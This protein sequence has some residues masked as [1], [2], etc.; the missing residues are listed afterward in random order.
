MNAKQ[1]MLRDITPGQVKMIHA[2]AGALGF[3]EDLYREI[4]R[5]RFKVRSS[6][7]L[8][9]FQAGRLIEELEEK[10]IQA[11]VW[12]KSAFKQRYEAL[13]GRPGFASVPQL[14]LIESTWAKV[15]RMQTPE[16]KAKSLRGFVF[17]IAKVSD[18]R[19]LDT[20]GAGKVII[21]LSQMEKR[22]ENF[23]GGRGHE[24]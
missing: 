22:S 8:A 2:L 14:A 10:A 24:K 5:D 13:S 4:L 21:A 19:F 20:A 1:S 16:L 3:D 9:H 11:G 17:K 23:H 12:T 6:K 7:E 18:L 15:S